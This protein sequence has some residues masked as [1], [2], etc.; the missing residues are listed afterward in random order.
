MIARLDAVMLLANKE[1]HI[2]H[3]SSYVMN[4][5]ARVFCAIK[6]GL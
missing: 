6:G 3:V 5:I 1:Y 2:V 4:G